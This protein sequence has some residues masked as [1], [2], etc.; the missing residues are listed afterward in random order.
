MNK[1]RR[2]DRGGGKAWRTEEMRQSM[3]ERMGK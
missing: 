3:N 1:D 2:G